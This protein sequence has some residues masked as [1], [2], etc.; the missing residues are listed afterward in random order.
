MVMAC[1]QRDRLDGVWRLNRRRSGQLRFVKRSAFVLIALVLGCGNPVEIDYDGPVADWPYWGGDQGATHH[2]PLDQITKENVE[3][4]QAKQIFELA[5]GPI[6][7]DAHKSLVD[8]GIVVCPDI[9]CSAGGVIVS[10]FEWYT[11]LNEEYWDIEKVRK[12][13]KTKIL[14]IYEDV[15]AEN[16]VD[17]RRA[18]IKVALKRLLK[19]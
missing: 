3:K 11:N 12:E 16:E 19:N 14:K 15:Q 18:A 5:N 9:L 2:S 10:Y 8:R 6:S 1:T 7:F 13:L 17:L 4:I